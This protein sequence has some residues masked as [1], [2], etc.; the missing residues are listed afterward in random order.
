MNKT[1][2]N[3]TLSAVALYLNKFLVN[4][5][6]LVDLS[7]KGFALR[8]YWYPKRIKTHRYK[9]TDYYPEIRNTRGDTGD[10]KNTPEQ[11]KLMIDYPETSI[12]KL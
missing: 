2:F 5:Y 3:S 7:E 4:V 10:W 11:L 6:S 1:W 12:K 9:L 8:F